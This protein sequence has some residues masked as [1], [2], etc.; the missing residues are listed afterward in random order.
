MRD[1]LMGIATLC[2]F[3]ALVGIIKPYMKNLRRK[4]F[5]FSALGF[6]VL[7]MIVV[8]TDPNQRQAV[9]NLASDSSD[10]K[11]EIKADAKK[12]VVAPD[13]KYLEQLQREIA[14]LKKEPSLRDVPSTKE[15][16]LIGV[17]LIG[18]RV[19]ILEDAPKNLRAETKAAQAEYV[20]LIKAYQRD[21]FPKLRMAQGKVWK[22]A[23]WENDIDVAILG[24]SNS[25]VRL[26]AG[27]FAANRNIKAT[28]EAAAETLRS[29]RFKK[30]SFEWYRGAD[31]YQ[32]TMDVP[33]DD[34]V[35]SFSESGMW[36]PLEV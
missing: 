18:A 20:R 24:P 7:M 12:A 6:F 11:S 4:H 5:A 27:M 3:A 10:D 23:L 13:Q 36:I 30:N 32:Y 15:G 2:F 25:T 9:A 17:V 19:K 8:P 16:V 14:S 26:T 1:V 28:H 29:L 31:G 22:E 34:V 21:A 33:A 35:A